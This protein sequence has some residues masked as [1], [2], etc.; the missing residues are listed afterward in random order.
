MV[1]LDADQ[2]LLP[3]NIPVSLGTAWQQ[4]IKYLHLPFP[5]QHHSSRLDGSTPRLPCLD[6]RADALDGW[7]SHLVGLDVPDAKEQDMEAHLG[8]QCVGILIRADMQ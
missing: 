7:S 5:I 3:L 1:K 4:R 8:E 6:W 2:T